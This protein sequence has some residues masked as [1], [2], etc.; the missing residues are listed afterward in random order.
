MTAQLLTSFLWLL[1][2]KWV[3][4]CDKKKCKNRH[5]PPLNQSKNYDTER[6]ECIKVK[7]V[8]KYIPR[9]TEKAR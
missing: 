3:D 8:Q 7:N 2:S 6:K 4:Y 9:G 5:P 1:E